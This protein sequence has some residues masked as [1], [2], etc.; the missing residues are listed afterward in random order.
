[1]GTSLL[2]AAGRSTCRGACPAG[3]SCGSYGKALHDG[4]GQTPILTPLTPTTK[5]C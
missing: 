3:G 5:W 2:A 1:M 4:R